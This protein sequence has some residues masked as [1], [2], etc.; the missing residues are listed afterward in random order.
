[1]SRCEAKLNK[2]VV[3]VFQLLWI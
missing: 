1:M 3:L 2:Y